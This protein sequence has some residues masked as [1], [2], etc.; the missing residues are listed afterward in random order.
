MFNDLVV[1][2]VRFLHFFFFFLVSV[3]LVSLVLQWI[4][5]QTRLS[6]FT[7][8]LKHPSWKPMTRPSYSPS[9]TH[10]HKKVHVQMEYFLSFWDS[11]PISCFFQSS[12]FTVYKFKA[13]Q[14]GGFADYYEISDLFSR[15]P[16]ILVPHVRWHGGQ[17]GGVPEDERPTFQRWSTSLPSFGR[18]RKRLARGRNWGNHNE[19]PL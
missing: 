18:T 13:K 8:T 15:L 17:A 2:D 10:R 9:F 19:T 4:I 12:G 5:Q 16:S 11:I 14:V 1:L 6:G 7:S 3:P